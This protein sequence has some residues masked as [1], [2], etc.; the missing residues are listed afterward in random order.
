MKFI[1]LKSVWPKWQVPPAHQEDRA[2]DSGKPI[3][4]QLMDFL[5]PYEFSGGSA[6]R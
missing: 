1:D 3:F 5:S 2:H 4:S 6:K